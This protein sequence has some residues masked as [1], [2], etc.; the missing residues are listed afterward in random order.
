MMYLGHLIIHI[1]LLLLFLTL[2]MGMVAAK[3]TVL[4][5]QSDNIQ[6]AQDMIQKGQR[7]LKQKK[8]RAAIKYFERSHTRVPDVKNLFTLG[9]IYS[10]LKQCPKALSYWT[11]AQ[12]MCGRCG[13]SS[14]LDQAIMKHTKSCS[15][16][17]SVQSL[18][19]AKVI[20]DQQEVGETPYTG[21]LLH[22]THTLV[23]STLGHLNHQVRIQ[24][25]RGRPVNI[26][27][28]MTPKGRQPRL[29][30]Q[31]RLPS[32]QPPLSRPP[33]VKPIA[34]P[35]L[36]AE[37]WLRAEQINEQ[38]RQGR[39]ILK[40]VLLSSGVILGLSAL[41]LY[42]YTTDRYR[43]LKDKTRTNYEQ[44]EDLYKQAMTADTIQTTS[45]VLGVI[46]LIAISSTLL[47]GP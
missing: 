1:G 31:E 33:P 47:I 41:G 15:T 7:L 27:V 40:T 14:Q 20:I 36:P 8:Y 29:S 18:P 39:R 21:R 35:S 9:A 24:A 43:V 46:S 25:D 23:L 10:K 6:A 30:N 17:L 26:D 32:L 5:Q 22:G 28:V 2:D 42:A 19:R 13:L 38:S 34:K 12:I 4:D 44:D 37:D 16:E 3:S 45:G 11:S